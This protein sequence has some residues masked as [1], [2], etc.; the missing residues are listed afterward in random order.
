MRIVFFTH[1]YPPEVNAPA[2]RT[3]EHARVWARDGHDVTIV[4]CA[5]NHPSGK[6][7]PGYR[8][9]LMQ[10]E[11]QDGIEIVRVWTYLAANEGFARRTANYVSYALSSALALP[12]IAKPDVVV[13][14]S[15]QFFCG[16]TGLLA[17]FVLRVPWVLEIRDL[18]PESIV[19]VGAMKKGRVTRFLE[20]LE[21][22]AYRRADGIVSVTD[23]F[24][25]HISERGGAGKIAVIK[26]GANL[27]FFRAGADS[28]D[29]R[30][31]LGLEGK[32][33][34]AYVGTHGMAHG[35]DTI[36]DAAKLLE[37]SDPDIV[38]LLV[39]DGAERARLEKR[40]D[41]MGLANVLM[42]GQ[43]PK[44]DMPG[45]W[46]ATDASIIHLRKDDL[47]KK[48]LP[49]KMFEAMAMSCPIVL[50][51]EGE[52]SDVLKE[53]GAGLAIEPGD[54]QQLASAVRQLARDPELCRRLGAQGA[55]HVREH[56]DR[57]VLAKRYIGILNAAV[58]RS[59]SASV[60]SA[61]AQSAP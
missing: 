36:L 50:G 9:R 24:V 49:S 56:Y 8:N 19:T 14:T 41:D 33:V 18:W 43:L 17:K 26:N 39:G 1:Y 10:R 23:S 2:S 55:A 15:P 58:V 22:L 6:V 42:L 45:I 11:M 28:S 44:A 60:P 46:S 3:S 16:L 51:V 54:A 32:F 47:F 38:F 35:L 29:T 34:A 21:R 13:S 48:V 7:Y 59:K 30:R 53:A 5:P 31:K 25:P 57:S 37:A 40:K 27:D 61:K 12:R 4:T 52:A 20:W